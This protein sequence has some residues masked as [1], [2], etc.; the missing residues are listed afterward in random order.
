MIDPKATYLYAGVEYPPGRHDTLPEAARAA[1]GIKPPQAKAQA[2]AAVAPTDPLAE[3]VGDAKLAAALRETGYGDVAA[4][5]AA[6][7]ADLTQVKGVGEAT[8]TKL[9]SATAG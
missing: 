9:R 7:D 2:Q 5:R 1:L 8:L 6:S 4:I 3:V